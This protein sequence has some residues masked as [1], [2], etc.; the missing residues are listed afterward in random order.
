MT[1]RTNP[2]FLKS[3]SH[4]NVELR[5]FCFPYA[6]GAAFVYRDWANHLPSTVQVVPVEL[7]GRGARL[8]ETPFVSVP[9]LISELSEVITPLLDVPFVFFGHSMGAVIA[10]E[11]ARSL[12][13]KHAVEP[14]RLLVSGRRAPELPDDEPITYNLP[15]PELIDELRRL[16][17][18]PKEV[19]ENAELMALM[20]PLIRADFQLVQSYEYVAEAPLR[21]PIS[22][23]G[24]LQDTEV[25]R[26]S[27]QL[28]ENQTCR[29]FTLHMLPGDH[30]FLRSSQSLLLGLLGQKLREVIAGP[31]DGSAKDD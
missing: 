11:L 5:L 7:P 28:W 13:R 16:Q 9:P 3:R 24:G 29:R 4:G 20:I 15:A 1:K 31:G 8:A 17:G 6:G 2:W 12:R 14:R 19:L 27:L 21:C 10:F 26:E 18:T 22:V 25:P 23:F 30:F